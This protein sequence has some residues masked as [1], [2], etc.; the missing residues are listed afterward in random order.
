MPAGG[1]GDAFLHLPAGNSAA[2]E[3][4]RGALTTPHVHQTILMRALRFV[5]TAAAVVSFALSAP[6]AQAQLLPSVGI[7]GGLNFSNISDAASARLDQSVGYHVG[8][9]IDLSLPLVPV[10]FRGSVLYV[11]AGDIAFPSPVPFFGS[12]AA[13]EFIAV[14]IDAKFSLGLPLVSPYGFLGP[15]IRFPMGELRDHDNVRDNAWALNLGVGADIGAF[16]GP[17]VFAELRYGIDL[18]GFVDADDTI[19]VSPFYLRLGIGF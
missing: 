2:K 8:A 4:L 5:L 11:R 14:P 19:R 3:K 13:I 15:E 7:T 18:T 12:D 17:K 16:I 10:G 6:V 9:Y 1:D